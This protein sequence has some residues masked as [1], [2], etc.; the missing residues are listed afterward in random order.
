MKKTTVLLVLFVGLAS[1]FAAQPPTAP[2]LVLETG[3][4]TAR[5]TRVATDARGRWYLTAADDK[6][7][8]LWDSEGRL[9]ST[10]RVPTGPGD[11]G[12]LYSCALSPDGSTIAVGGSTGYAWDESDCIYLFDRQ[13]GSLIRRLVGLEEVINHLAFSADGSL[14]GCALGKMGTRIYDTRTWNQVFADRD[15]GGD[16]YSFVF[17][18]DGSYAAASAL[19]GSLRLYRLKPPGLIAKVSSRGGKEPF[20]LCFS[21][22]GKLLACGFNDCTKVDVY[23]VSKKGL[24]FS[25]SPDGTGVDNGSLS[26]VEFSADGRSLA[27]GGGWWQGD[28]RPVRM[29]SNAGRGAYRDLDAGLS[30]MI[31]DIKA[32]PDGSF[33]VASAEPVLSKLSP[34]GVVAFSLKPRKADYRGNWTG[35]RLSSDART[36]DYAYEQWGKR[37]ASF[38]LVS[39]GMGGDNTGLTAPDSTSLPITDWKNSY[40]PKLGGTPLTLKQYE[41]SRAVA[42]A[43]G[44][45]R[46]LL[47][48]DWY[49]RCFDERGS[50]VWQQSVPGVV[51]AVNVSPDGKIGIAAYGDGTIRFHR[52]SD[53]KELLAFFPHSDGRRWVLWT[54]SG[55]Y[56]CSPGGEDLIGW[57]V[58]NGANQAADFFPASR[59]RGTYY[60]PDV[61]SLVLDTLDE[62]QAIAFANAAAGGRQESASILDKR[63]PIVT[64]TSPDSGSAFSS[65][66]VTLRYRLRTPGDAPVTSIKALVDGR[67]IEDARGLAVVAAADAD[68]SFDLSVPARDCTVSLVAEN[69]NGSSE[70]A[71]IGLVWKG[72][73]AGQDEFVIKPKLYVLA[74]GVS[75]YEKPEYHLNYAAKDARDL[76][77]LLARGGPLYRGVE[78]KVL[79]DA[80]ADKDDILDGLDWIEKQTTS[81]DIA[82]ILFSGHGINDSNGDYYY[83]PVNADIDR[84]KRTGVPFSDI[85]TTVS[86]IAGKVLFFIDTCHSGN[87]MDTG[88]RA[89]G[90][91]RDIGAVINELASAENGA[92]VFAS[93][94]GSQYS[95]EDPAWGNGAFTKALLEGLAGAADYDK[96]GRITVNMLD[97][98][99]SERVKDLTGGKQ[100]PTTT[101]P[102]N[103]PDFPV[104]MKP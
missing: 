75:A 69:R 3:F 100:T 16:S 31:M 21:P 5:I 62:A 49:L 30:D 79:T 83:L 48:A 60:R 84:L 34:Q 46:F 20:G 25:Y 36:F 59:F 2:S 73:Q 24:S 27:A 12:K 85:K 42:I 23:A 22:D 82:V 66:A 58:N 7:A 89:A 56:D 43:P 97:L 102:P 45:S 93:S 4:H 76:A 51:W 28:K 6:S 78:T 35:L 10:F 92:V 47:G 37:P 41:I 68:Q 99:I 72:A 9:L 98:Y 61:V 29:W 103:V 77:A 15:F 18:P 13:S 14:L 44:S 81:K 65:G 52:M 53:G 96:T 26:C 11:E 86:H 64:I 80:Q 88:R 8:R 91:E 32:L 54:P 70:A 50:Q 17:S 38:D 90:A 87:L 19:D 67:P 40:A 94:T 33:L 101:K 71:S 74:V 57:Q 95:Y 104:A 55:Y 39:R 1:L 63:P